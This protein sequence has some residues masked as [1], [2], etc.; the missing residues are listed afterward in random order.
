MMKEDF[1]RC[2]KKI[3]KW[4]EQEVKKINI[5]GNIKNLFYLAIWNCLNNGIPVVPD[6]NIMAKCHKITH[7]RLIN[8]WFL[9]K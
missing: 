1:S 4:H 9:M 8:Q 7:E 5:G 3:Q 6:I 2:S